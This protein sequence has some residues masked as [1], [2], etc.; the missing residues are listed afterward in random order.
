M[1]WI[2]ITYHRKSWEIFITYFTTSFVKLNLFCK[3]YNYEPQ[4]TFPTTPLRLEKKVPCRLT[5][6][7]F[8]FQQSYLLSINE[9]KKQQWMLHIDNY[10]FQ[11]NYYV[12]FSFYVKYPTKATLCLIMTSR[13]THCNINILLHEW[14]PPHIGLNMW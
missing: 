3:H 6:N 13:D 2:K 5:N 10:T 11:L 1:S 7:Y 9:K 12:T 4:N 8:I 14:Y